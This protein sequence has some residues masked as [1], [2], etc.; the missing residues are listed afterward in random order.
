MNVTWNK[1]IASFVALYGTCFTLFVSIMSLNHGIRTAGIHHYS[2]LCLIVLGLFAIGIS[3][4]LW[5]G[6]DWSRVFLIVIS[7]FTTGVFIA[8]AVVD[9][10]EK[11]YNFA[12]AIGNIFFY[13]PFVITPI[14]LTVCL[15]HPDVKRDFHTKKR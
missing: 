13:I 9:F 10:S 2:N 11:T 3:L 1:L 8:L 12:S 4:P 5:K 6:L 7:C 15:I 14:F